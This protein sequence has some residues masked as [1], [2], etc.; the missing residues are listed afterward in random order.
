MFNDK[1][2]NFL[3]PFNFRDFA[4]LG[5]KWLFYEGDFKND[6]K[7]GRGKIQLTNG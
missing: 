1:P 7:H 2:E 5:N 4:E 6:S 3:H